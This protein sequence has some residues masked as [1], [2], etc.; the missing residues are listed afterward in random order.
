MHLAVRSAAVGEDDDGASYAGQYST[1]LG[2]SPKNLLNA[3]FECYAS[4]WSDRVMVYRRQ[5]GIVPTEPHLSVIV[6]R[7]LLP[8]FAGVLFTRHPLSGKK[9]T[10]VVEG[11]AGLEINS[12]Q[13]RL[14]PE[15][16]KYPENPGTISF[17]CPN[18]PHFRI[19]GKKISGGFMIS[20][21]SWK[22]ILARDGYG[23]GHRKRS[24]ICPS[25]QTYYLWSFSIQNRI[26]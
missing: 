2:V 14:L 5:K 13:E 3:I 6:Q 23:M 15:D 16:G 4:W 26:T 25:S 20:E 8:E 7:Q 12:Y 21:I 9:D 22:T 1:V 11:V 10:M 18:N 24:S 19:S 17:S